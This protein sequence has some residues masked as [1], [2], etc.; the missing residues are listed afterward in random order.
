MRKMSVA[1]ERKIITTNQGYWD[2]VADRQNQRIAE[3]YRGAHRNY[4]HF[5]ADYA[6]GYSL[7][8]CGKEPPPYAIACLAGE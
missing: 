1:K 7:G 3:W 8:L 5:D 4:G 6:E 2:G